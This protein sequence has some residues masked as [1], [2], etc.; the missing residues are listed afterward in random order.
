MNKLKSDRLHSH[1]FFDYRSVKFETSSQY[2]PTA[3]K[4]KTRTSCYNYLLNKP[5]L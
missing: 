2:G 4:Q 3:S 5:T 1:L